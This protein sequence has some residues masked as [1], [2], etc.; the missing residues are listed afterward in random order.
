MTKQLLCV[1][2]LLTLATW[3][4]AG[5]KRESGPAPIYSVTVVERTTRAVNYQYRSEPTMIDFLGTVLLPMGKGSALVESKQGRTEIDAKF[6]NLAAPVRFG[7]EYLTYVL[8]ALTPD[9]GPHNIGEVVPGTSDKAHLRVTTDLQAFALIVTAEPYS[10]VRQ[11]GDVV[12]M[13]NEIRPDTVGKTEQVEARYELMPRGHYAWQVP[14]GG[15]TAENGAPKVSMRKY[16]E[17][18]ELYQA[19]NAVGIARAAGAGQYA[20]NTFAKAEKL[21]ADANQLEHHNGDSKRV[22]Q[23]AREAAETAEDARVIAERRKQEEKL[24][25]AA[26]QVAQAQA[27][28]QQARSDAQAAR[29]EADAERAARERAEANASAARQQRATPPP[30]APPAPREQGSAVEPSV[31]RARLLE[32]LNVPLPTRDT[33]RGLVATIRDNGFSGSALLGN[34]SS[35]VA[36]VGA[37]VAAHPGLRIEVDGHDDGPDADLLSKQRAEGVRAVL[38]SQG[39]PAESVSARGWGNSRPL[40]SDTTE[41]GR[42][43]NRRVEITVSGE[44]IGTLPAW[45]RTYSLE[46]R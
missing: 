18:S 11:P 13:E 4:A 41:T 5:Q 32:Q 1:T 22:V 31:L 10:A 6:E 36:R 25:G 37:M 24:A 20:P 17:L 15:K 12:V 28:A 30:P 16:E 45:D 3:P 2:V 29:A 19:Q 39:L 40:A 27:E 43:E 38:V 9:G 7:R 46:R 44:P 23:D 14:P 21:L 8:W 42:E 34:T 26:A 35:Q 33:P